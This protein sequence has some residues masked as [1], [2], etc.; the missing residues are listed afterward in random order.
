MSREQGSKQSEQASERVS[1]AKRAGE[2][3]RASG[4]V[5]TSGFLVILDLSA[6]VIFFSEVLSD[7]Y[8]SDFY[9]S[10]L[11]YHNIAW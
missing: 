6:R 8:T 11:Q 9:T 10:E 1:F 3:S 7:I 2:A 5:P 4:P